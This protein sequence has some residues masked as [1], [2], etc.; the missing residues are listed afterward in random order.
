MIVDI[1]PGNSKIVTNRDGDKM[2]FYFAGKEVYRVCKYNGNIDIIKGTLDVPR[3]NVIFDV[4][5]FDVFNLN[6]SDIDMLGENGKE[7][8]LGFLLG[9]VL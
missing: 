4:E 6:P 7:D 3:E 1:V 2:L 9:E 8:I 5:Y